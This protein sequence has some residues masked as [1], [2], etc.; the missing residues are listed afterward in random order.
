MW[1]WSLL[2]G[3]PRGGNFPSHILVC[4]MGLMT[5]SPRLTRGGD[6]WS[7]SVTGRT[8]HGEGT[9]W[10]WEEGVCKGPA[11]AKAQRRQQAEKSK[12]AVAVAG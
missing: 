2:P 5:T 11:S 8:S 6:T 9:S 4:K 1:T 12:A 3:T 7:N 10:E